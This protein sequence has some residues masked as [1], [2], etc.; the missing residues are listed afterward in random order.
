MTGP[1][2]SLHYAGNGNFNNGTYEPGADG[3]NLADVNSPSQLNALPA[4]VKGLVWLGMTSGVTP[5]FIAAVNACIGNPNL[6]GFYISDEPPGNAAIAANLK[7]EADYIKAHVPGAITFMVEQNLSSNVSPVYY[8]NKSNTDIDLFGLDPYPVQTNVPNSPD[9]AIIPQ[10]VAAAEKAGISRSDIVPVYQAFG[11]GGFPSYI[12]PTPA[13]EQQ[14]LATWASVVPNPAFDYAYSWGTQAGD[15]A[16]STDQ[17]LQ[18]VFAAHNASGAGSAAP[19]ITSPANG[20]TV[21][22]TSDP[23]ISGTGVTGDTVTVSIDGSVAGTAPVL[24]GAWSYTP[25]KPLANASHSVTATQAAT[26]GPSSAPSATDTFTVNVSTAPAA[27]TITSPANGSTVATTSDPVISG[28]GVTGDTVTVSI[29]GS[30]A[31]TAP[32]LGG[33]WSYT[34]TKPLA[35]ASHSVTATQ[36]AT[37]GPSSAP[38]ATDTF[39]VNVS[40]AP[41][42][43][44][45]TSPANGSTVATTSD[46]VISGTGVTG[47][48]VT[49]S[50]DGSVAGTA[51]VLGGAWSYTPTQ[52]LANASHSVTATQAATG[53]PSSAP[54]ATD[55]FTVNVSTAPAAPTITSP[56]NGSTVATTSDPVISGTGVTG[57]TVTVSIDGS[58]A[59]TAPVLGGAWSYTPTQPLA[60]ASHSVTAT[61]AATGGPSSAPSATDTFTVNVSTAPAAPTIT[62]PANGSTVATTSDPVISGTGVTGDTVTVSIDGSVAGTAP[63]LG[64]AWSYTPSKPLANASHSVTA[65][66]AATGGP[67]SAPSATDTFTVNVSTAPAAPTITSPANGSTVATTSDPVISGTGVTGDTVTVSIDGSVAGTAP[68]LGG[69]WSYTPSKPLAN[70]SHSVTATQA[71]TGGPSS[72]PSATDTFTVNVSTAPAAPTITSPANG[73]TVATTS[74][75]VISGTGVTGDT[76]TVSIDG[77]VAGTAPVLGGAWSYTPTKPLAN[78]SHSVTATQAATGGPSSAPS[79]T[80]TFTVDAGN[81][82]LTI[83]TATVGPLTL[84]PANNHLTI[85]RAGAVTASS[86]DAVDGGSGATWSINNAGTIASLSQSGLALNSAGDSVVNSGSI[87]GYGGPGAYGVALERGGSLDNSSS[88]SITGG[89]D[90]VIAYDGSCRI[91]NAGTIKS[92]FDDAI[93]LFKG[94]DVTNDAGGVIQAPTSGGYGPAGVYI[95]SG[96]ANVT[97]R[98]AIQGMYGVYYDVAGTVENAGSISGTSYAIDFGANSIANRLIIDPGAVFNGNVDGN[99]GT[100]ELSAGLGSI[101]K[102]GSDAFSG[103][104]TLNNDANAHWTLTGDN[105]I[106]NVT[107]DGSLTVAGLLDVSAAVD[108]ACTGQFLLQSGASMEV[109]ADSAAHSEID[110]T[111]PAALI[112][113]DV[114]RFGTGVGSSSYVGPQ[115][116]DFSRGDSIDL[117]D[118]SVTKA[119][120]LYDATTGVLQLT[121]GSSQVATFNFQNASL[122]AGSF[123]LG[124]DGDG[125]TLL[126]HG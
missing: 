85:T 103:F 122:G 40:T 53:G 67:S 89:D 52:P 115:I 17:S 109:A 116:A 20:S 87:S 105:A 106:A 96:S 58:V 50:I 22:T 104:Q 124:S 125:G 78:A 5:A 76:V 98:G 24:G 75:P 18:A 14:I 12:L 91:N 77:S 30:V 119:A 60:N 79:A 27:P 111:G 80:D 44:T 121:N 114:S 36:A 92:T 62:S 45:I 72:A 59:G 108:A 35:N 99:G 37:G 11:G 68:V 25:T 55:T 101:G 10:A 117:H 1:T 15:T 31:G 21:A 46:P 23:V 69:A 64:G 123:S 84:V 32:V 16:L 73:S 2:T 81:S 95:A 28:T 112:V 113:D 49:V 90:A 54:S 41:A 97:N 6:Y 8:F 48:T 70:A 88:G 7:S 120:M 86:A 34:P 4:G 43:P 118:F 107:N 61:Q 42:A 51:P 110:F 19:T 82:S 26:G 9:Y 3:F 94:G 100:L 71:A 47:D 83:S 65:T 93:G 63:V 33:A 102:I 74:D 13:Q 66:Q 29:D 38:S 126:K 39:T 57:D 56:A